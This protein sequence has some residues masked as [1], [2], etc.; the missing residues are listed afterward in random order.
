VSVVKTTL[1]VNG[2]A[3][4]TSGSNLTSGRLSIAATGDIVLNGSLTTSA[5]APASLPTSAQTGEP[6]VSGNTPAID[7][8]AQQNVRIAHTVTCANNTSPASTG[9][10]PNDISGLY[11]TSQAGEVV[12]SDGTLKTAHPARVYCNSSGDA[13]PCTGGTKSGCDSATGGITVTAA[14]FALNGSLQTDN[15]N[16]GCSLGTLTVN[17]GVYSN[18]RGPVGQEWE[19]P[20]SG[21]TV[22]SYSGYKLQLNYVSLEQAGLGY[23]PAL[24]VTSPSQAGGTQAHPWQVLSISGATS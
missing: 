17:G 4:I 24:G 14:I 22:R 12:N 23:V 18:F 3:T 9:Y 1:Y 15:Y 21:A 2:D 13:Y 6:Y 10:C 7:L 5:A 11:S 8:V 16:R 20:S 19:V